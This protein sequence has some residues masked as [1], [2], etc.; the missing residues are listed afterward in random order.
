MGKRAIVNRDL[1]ISVC[2]N[3]DADSG[4]YIRL[5]PQPQFALKTITI[6]L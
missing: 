2:A 6:K 1:P 3:A 5:Q 4:S